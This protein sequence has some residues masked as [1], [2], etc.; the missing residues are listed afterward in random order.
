MEDA[1]GNSGDEESR[2]RGATYEKLWSPTIGVGGFF[3]QLYLIALE[4]KRYWKA[5]LTKMAVPSKPNIQDL[6]QR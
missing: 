6:S 1:I 3:G 2:P 4:L 5:V